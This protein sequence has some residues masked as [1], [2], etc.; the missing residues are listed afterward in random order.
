MWEKFYPGSIFLAE[1]IHNY[2]VALWDGGSAHTLV[3]QWKWLSHAWHNFGT[4]LKCILKPQGLE[5][6]Q[7]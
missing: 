4:K 3:M 6:R 2:R 5:N 7:E 1:W